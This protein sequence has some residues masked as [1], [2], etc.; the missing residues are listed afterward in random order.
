M[1]IL[2]T[3]ATGLIG[4]EVGKALVR[5]GHTVTIISRNKAKAQ[6]E[7]PFPCD[8]IE[9]DLLQRPIVD[10]RLREIEGVL[11]LLGENVGEARWTQDKKKKILDSRVLGTR[12]LIASLKQSEAVRLQVFISA[13]AI[14][15]YGDRGDEVLTEES[16]P[17]QDFLSG[18]CT[19]WESEATA[20]RKCFPDLRIAILRLGVVL[21]PFGGALT[22]MLT[23]FRLGLGACLGNGEQWLSWI[24]LADVAGIVTW[25]LRNPQTSGILNAVSPMQVRNREFS[26]FLA[27]AFQ[28]GL[29]PSLPKFALKIILGEMSGLLLGSQR[30]R[31]KRLLE[32]GY[33]FR[34]PDL[35]KVFG[36]VASFF[37]NGEMLLRS[38][39]YLPSKR[40]QVFPFF[41]DARNL[42]T[43]TP[44]MLRFQ[45]TGVS[46]KEV[47]A[48]TLIDY[49][50]KIRGVPVTWRTR[51]DQWNPSE[52]FIDSQFKG[53]YRK[54]QHLHSFEDL[55]EGTLMTDTV[56]YKVPLGWMGWFTAGWMVSRDINGIFRYR[57]QVCARQDFNSLKRSPKD[58][59]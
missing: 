32:M 52:N 40:D 25:V 48:G 31:P 56:R 45:I 16:I 55:G 18:V 10:P 3:G 49:R 34:E 14:G 50:L 59:A 29:A 8:V 39:Q 51:I 22:K 4:H 23:P 9:G 15:F 19:Q 42:E 21:S 11:H 33:Q 7:I 35:K 5:E 28:K 44:A 43:I 37:E 24:D 12:N 27:A 47:M 13:S 38:E 20:A 1:K 30:V 53:P 17:G 2:I 57:R 58:P 26:K 36:R 41:S 46:T 54:W 6:T